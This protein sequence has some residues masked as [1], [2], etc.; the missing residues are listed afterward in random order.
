MIGAAHRAETPRDAS[1]VGVVLSTIPA[2]LQLSP[3]CRS[4]FELRI[5][6]KVDVD[7]VGL[8]QEHL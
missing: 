5:K 2:P 8:D 6:S 7:V 4:S 3:R 1:G